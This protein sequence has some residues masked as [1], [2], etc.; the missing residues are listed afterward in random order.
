MN[1][2]KKRSCPTFYKQSNNF[3]LNH[4]LF[5]NLFTGFPEHYLHQATEY[6]KS[7]LNNQE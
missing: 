3:S 5:F 2:A 1:Y 4:N 6:Q 7:K